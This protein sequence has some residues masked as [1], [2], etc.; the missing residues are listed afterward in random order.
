M[1]KEDGYFTRVA[2]MGL[3]WMV[4]LVERFEGCEELSLRMS[5][6]SSFQAE[7]ISR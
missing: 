1:N 4:I 3:T 2:K 7:G 6:E 5:E